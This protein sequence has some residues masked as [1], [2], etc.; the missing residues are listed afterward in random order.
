MLEMISLVEDKNDTK[1][2]FQIKKPSQPVMLGAREING[3]NNILAWR[4]SHYL[5]EQNLHKF[6]IKG[7]HHVTYYY[8][9]NL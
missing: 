2:I 8:V 5:F 7:Q 3:I 4:I 9:E 6:K 1:I